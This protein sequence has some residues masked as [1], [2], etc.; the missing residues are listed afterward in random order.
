MKSAKP[1][2]ESLNGFRPDGIY[3]NCFVGYPHYFLTEY[4]KS[5]IGFVRIR[6]NHQT[7]IIIDDLN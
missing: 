5:A 4:Q 2:L 7:V 3:E 6:R 1:H